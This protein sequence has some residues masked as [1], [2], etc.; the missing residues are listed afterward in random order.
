MTDIQR[1]RV[2]V[3]G[4]PG[5]PGVMTFYE[6]DAATGQ[7]ALR[8]FLAAMTANFPLATSLQ[9]ET[10]GDTINDATGAITGTWTGTAQ[11]NVVGTDTGSYSAPAGFMA[12]W[13]TTAI[14]G[15]RRL[16][17]RNY[18]VPASGTSFDADGAA[19]PSMVATYSGYAQTLV[20]TTAGNLLVWSRPRVATP[21]WTDRNGHVHPALAARAGS[22]AAVVTGAIS[23]KAVVLRSRRD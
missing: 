2:T 12:V 7:A 19:A 8:A 11:A 3:T 5:G 23:S 16:R 6:A 22:S 13:G 1:Q 15:G 20:T 10:N 14:V 18:F 9:I 17:G 4:Y 21:S